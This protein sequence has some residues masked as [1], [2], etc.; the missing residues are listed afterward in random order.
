VTPSESVQK[1]H[2][3]PGASVIGGSCSLPI[4]S[5]PICVL[6][7]ARVR[8]CI[9]PRNGNSIAHVST[10]LQNNSSADDAP[11]DGLLGLAA[12]VRLPSPAELPTC[13]PRATGRLQIADHLE[14]G[15]GSLGSGSR[16]TG[17]GQPGRIIILF[18]DDS[19]PRPPAPRPFARLAIARL[20]IGSAAFV[21]LATLLQVVLPARQVVHPFFPFITLDDRYLPFFNLAG[22]DQ[23]V[24][25][26]SALDAHI[27]EHLA[28]RLP[29]FAEMTPSAYTEILPRAGDTA[30]TSPLAAWLGQ[31]DQ[32]QLN[33][34]LLYRITLNEQGF[35]S[36][37]VAQA[38]PP[39]TLRVVAAGDSLTFGFGLLAEKTWTHLLE[40]RLNDLAP[41]GLEVEVVNAGVIAFDSTLGSE[42]VRRKVLPLESDW[43]ILG[44][45][46]ND[47]N[48]NNRSFLRI[49][50]LSPTA[51]T[52]WQAEIADRAS[53][54]GQ[55]RFFA[56][57]LHI[58][59]WLRVGLTGLA[60]KLMRRPGTLA[61]SKLRP[62]LEEARGHHAT[63]PETYRANL[64]SLITELKAR[65]IRVWLLNSNITSSIYVPE[66]LDLAN[67]QQ[68]PYIDFRQV[69]AD[70]LKRPAYPTHDA[71]SH[72]RARVLFRVRLP[73][74]LALRRPKVFVIGDYFST[75]ELGFTAMRDDG[76]EPDR[77]QQDDV[78]SAA[79][80]IRLGTLLAFRF[81]YTFDDDTF[82][83]EFSGWRIY[84]KF[85]VQGEPERIGGHL[86]AIATPIYAWDDLT[87]RSDRAFDFEPLMQ[88]I[89]HPNAAGN[90]LIAE[91]L[92]DGLK[93]EM[94]W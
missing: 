53:L 1:D 36:R 12:H 40:Q 60:I 3:G 5:V 10:A 66:L 80:P 19:T 44:Y 41:I 27:A 39:Q 25:T 28:A 64:Q 74:D 2:R 14:I 77:A 51:E 72:G 91:A 83:E 82:V 8:D 11:Q 16:W 26:W 52:P 65:G 47:Y 57:G 61:L 17:V 45:G 34:P 85:E 7:A 20:A 90:A 37:P 54:L 48:V 67:T 46:F 62:Y 69:F 13:A 68:L 6:E 87:D 93:N 33:D 18:M 29:P 35:R 78:Y 23:N 88:E 56:S 31:N 55:A 63:S 94:R 59:Q 70:A 43:V 4:D 73:H 92:A 75:V 50:P 71:S 15:L 38:K 79:L 9:H 58:T 81:A 22:F 76:A 84:R 49:S 24:Y 42:M 32:A 89:C 86:P 30:E 21:A